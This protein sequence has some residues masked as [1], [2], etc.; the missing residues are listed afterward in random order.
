MD[1]MAG[2]NISVK[3]SEIR[4]LQRE[5]SGKS[6][7]YE[8][9][10]T[11]EVHKAALNIESGAKQNASRVTDE[12][13]LR[14]SIHSELEP[15]KPSANVHSGVFYAPYIE[16][17]TGRFAASYLADKAAEVKRYA[18]TFFKTGKGRTRTA[19]FLFPAMDAEGP[20]L[21][22]RLRGLKL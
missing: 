14:A 7:A 9:A 22:K 12:G 10:V 13:R 3:Q 17:G 4:R 6:K 15:G 2:L 5:L 19:P 18:M 21:I 1:L 16:F 20:K 11:D 8:S